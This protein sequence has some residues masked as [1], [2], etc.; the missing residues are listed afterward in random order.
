LVKE[1]IILSFLSAGKT[2]ILF[3]AAAA[4]AAAAD[5]ALSIT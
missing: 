3:E 1:Q 2:G 5:L 4:A